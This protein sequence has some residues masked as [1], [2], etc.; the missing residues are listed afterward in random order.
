MPKLVIGSWIRFKGNSH[1]A[2]NLG[3]V[4]CS[5]ANSTFCLH[6]FHSNHHATYLHDYAT[7]LDIFMLRIGAKTSGLN[8][9][10]IAL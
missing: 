8:V 4:A 2:G 5:N 3:D 7:L 6:H 10:Q 9:V 1:I